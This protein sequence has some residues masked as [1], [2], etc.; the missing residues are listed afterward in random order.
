MV[1]VAKHYVRHGGVTHV[2]G[3]TFEAEFDRESEKRLIALGA[4]VPT[5]ET[6]YAENDMTEAYEATEEADGDETDIDVMSGIVT[7]PAAKTARPR[8]KTK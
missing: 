8:R 1:Y 3:E 7:A 5:E 4:V 2:P 6:A